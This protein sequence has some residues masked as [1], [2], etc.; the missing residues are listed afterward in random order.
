MGD[1]TVHNGLKLIA[2]QWLMDEI[3]IW[4]EQYLDTQRILLIEAPRCEGLVRG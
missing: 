3:D 2:G 1:G 4:S